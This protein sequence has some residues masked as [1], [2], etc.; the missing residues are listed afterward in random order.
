MK[1][2]KQEQKLEIKSINI[3][4]SVTTIGDY[5]FEGYE[6]LTSIT[7]SNSVTSIGNCAFL[8]CT[9]LTSINIPESVTSIG[10]GAFAGTGLT[11]INI[12]NSVTSIESWAFKDCTGLTSINIPN[13]VTSIG[14]CAF[15][16]CESLTT[17]NIPNSVTSIGRSVFFYCSSLTNIKI[18]N[19][20]TEI[21]GYAFYKTPW[22][23]DQPDGLLYLGRVAYKYKGDMPEGTSIKIKDGTTSIGEEAFKGCTG[24]TSITIPNSV[25][26]IGFAAFDFNLKNLYIDCKTPPY[27]ECIR[28]DDIWIPAENKDCTLHVP[29]GCKEAYENE[30]P[31]CYFEKIVDDL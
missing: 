7:I 24:L 25:T 6:N 15:S 2:T 13:S 16:G 31:W 11:S 18:P 3:P 28:Y 9:K 8:G 1:R 20:V 26:S 5:A 30:E 19:S 22:F 23:E 12:P 29:K 21:G 27:I 17:I 10:G 14:D 4:D